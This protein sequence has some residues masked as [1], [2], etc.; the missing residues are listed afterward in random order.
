MQLLSDWIGPSKSPG[1]GSTRKSLKSECT[2]L[3]FISASQTVL[4]STSSV[5]IGV[6]LIGSIGAWKRPSY[7]WI[8]KSSQRYFST[9]MS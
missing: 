1:S 7:F 3:N 8:W 5:I 9:A 6:P 4:R 2:S